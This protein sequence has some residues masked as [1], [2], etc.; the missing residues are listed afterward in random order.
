MIVVF[1][2]INI[3][4]MMQTDRLPKPGETL[5]ATNAM[6]SPGGKGANQAL[7]AKFAGSDVKLF[8]Q[9][10]NDHFG[11]ASLELLKEGGVDLTGVGTCDSNTGCASI[12]VDAGGENSIVLDTGA[13]LV[14]RAD[15]VPDADLGQDTVVLLQMEVTPGESWSLV[16]RAKERGARVVLN[17]APAAIV[18]NEVLAALDF[19]IVNELEAAAVAHDVGITTDTPTQIPRALARQ[20]GNTCIMTLGGAGLLCFGPDGGWSVPA[21]P[22]APVDTTAAGDAF[23]GGFAAAIDAGAPLEQALRRASVGAGLCCMA[24]G[25]Q[26]AQ[27]DRAAI[28]KALADLPASQKLI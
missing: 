15:Q 25:A 7:A 18:P 13:N 17:V 16:R 14:T 22:I 6:Y 24:R 2:S 12:W 9:V 11:P 28:D 3:D 1:G 20:Y 23:V 21:L 8:G 5:L 10:G 26:R 27:P 19:L 4:I